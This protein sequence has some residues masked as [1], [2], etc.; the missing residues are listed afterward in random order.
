MA[1]GVKQEQG[2]DSDEIFSPVSKKDFELFQMDIKIAF[3]Y[4]DLNEIYT[5]QPNSYEVHGKMSLILSSIKVY[6]GF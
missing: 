6:M 5:E 4:G 2:V 1:K 3:L